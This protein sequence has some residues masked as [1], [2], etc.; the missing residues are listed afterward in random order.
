MAFRELT[1]PVADIDRRLATRLKANNRVRQ[2]ALAAVSYF[3][4]ASRVPRDFR[5][6]FSNEIN[7]LIDRS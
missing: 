3:C 2:F 4:D 7:L 6:F 5:E 1:S